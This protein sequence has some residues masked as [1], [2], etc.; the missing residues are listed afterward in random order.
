MIDIDRIYNSTGEEQKVVLVYSAK[1]NQHN[2]AVVLQ[3][4]IE[5]L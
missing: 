3:E 4:T 2:H 5:Q 1:D